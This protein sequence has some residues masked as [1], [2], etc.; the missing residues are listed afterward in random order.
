LAREFDALAAAAD[1]RVAVAATVETVLP[2]LQAIY[3]VHGATAS[4][5]SEGSVLEVLT[6][7]QRDLADEVSG[8]RALLGGSDDG[9]RRDAALVRRI[10]R[11]FDETDVFPAVPAS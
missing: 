10:E 6:G 9:L 3:G 7:A 2:R 11:A 1:S 5:V 8:G 4:L